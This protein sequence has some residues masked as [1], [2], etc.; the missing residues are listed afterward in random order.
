MVMCLLL[1]RSA[2]GST[3]EEQIVCLQISPVSQLLVD[4]TAQLQTF[5]HT[6]LIFTQKHLQCTKIFDN[7]CNSVYTQI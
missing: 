6:K 4:H 1:G 5:D 2:V 3:N 7:C